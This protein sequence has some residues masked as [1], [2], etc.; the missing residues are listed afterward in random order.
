MASVETES[1]PLAECTAFQIDMLL[2]LARGGPQKGTRIH[3]RLTHRH[4]AVKSGVLYPNLNRLADRGLV[5]KTE[6]D[7]RTN[8]YALTTAGW[9]ALDAYAEYVT[10]CVGGWPPRGEL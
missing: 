2:V 6:R 10:T 3:E 9:E 8:E 7:G 4:T 5:S 1:T